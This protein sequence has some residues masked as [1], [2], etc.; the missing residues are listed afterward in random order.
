VSRKTFNDPELSFQV[1]C[2][3][4]VARFAGAAFLLGVLV[5]S[6]LVPSIAR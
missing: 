6:S 4:D 2:W 5:G 1:P 3:A